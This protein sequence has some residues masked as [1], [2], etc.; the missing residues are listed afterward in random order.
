MNNR[1]LGREAAYVA[2]D[3]VVKA[4]PRADDEVAVAYRVVRGDGAV[5]PRHPQ[6]VGQA[7]RI[8][9]DAHERGDNRDTRPL[10]KGHYL[11]RGNLP[12]APHHHHGPLRLADGLGG[13]L[14]L[15]S[16]P[17]HGRFVTRKVDFYVK[18]ARK[19]LVLNVLGNIDEHGSGSPSRGDVKGFFDDAR[20]VIHVFDQIV[21]LGHRPGDA[22]HVRLLK[23]VGA[24]QGRRHVARDRDKRRGIHVGG[25][26]TCH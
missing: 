4:Q 5:H 16:V 1:R 13:A 22:V 14:D 25:G 9:A 7:R 3:P 6:R 24:D 19:R 23:G 21:V 11:L 12:A 10:G 8:R 20:D 2:R 15:P 26:E 18:A 17:R